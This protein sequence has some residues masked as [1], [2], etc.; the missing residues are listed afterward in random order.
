MCVK[1]GGRES[2]TTRP[3]LASTHTSKTKHTK[4]TNTKK[5]W[6]DYPF[7][8]A[9][10]DMRVKSAALMALEL[11]RHVQQAY[12][13]WNRTGGADHIWL[14]SHD[15]GACWAPSEITDASIILT[16]WGRK[17]ADLASDSAYG[18]DNYT[19]AFGDPGAAKKFGTPA[20]AEDWRA[21]RRP[22][23]RCYVPGKVCVVVG[24]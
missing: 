10:G 18:P 8:G 15:E 7:W 22:G 13:Y 21:I 24:C 17:G 16:H 11:K 20:L 12:P 6:A 5:G 3:S 19:L 1:G 9:A 23:H 14:F 2:A 4:I